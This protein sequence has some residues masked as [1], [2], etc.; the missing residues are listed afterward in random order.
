[1]IPEKEEVEIRGHAEVDRQQTALYV[2]LGALHFWDQ[3]NDSAFF[4]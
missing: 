4:F 1:M 2:A 3:I